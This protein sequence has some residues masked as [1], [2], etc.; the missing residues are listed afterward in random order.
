M[1]TLPNIVIT[2]T[3]CT[4]KTT[5]AQQLISAAAVGRPAYALRHLEVNAL[6]RSRGCY[7]SYDAR[8]ETQVVD[9]EKLLDEMEKEIEDG[10]DRGG[11]VID[12]HG[13]DLF[14]ERWVDLVV[15]LRC[16]GRT[17]ELYDRMVKRGYGEAK[18]QENLDTE[19][20]GVVAEEARD[21]F[22]EGL[23]VELKSE[24]AEDV[25]ENVGRILEWIGK[26][27]EDHQGG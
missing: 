2:G 17:E 12:W 22:E 27:V 10:E 26:W 19:I 7:E 11:W 21:G 16:V 4:G 8:L 1:R 3:P 6:A 25:E 13:C 24:K 14:P 15:V 23:V 20:F 5:T 18:V 9:E